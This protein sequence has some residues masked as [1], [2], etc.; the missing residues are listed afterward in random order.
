MLPFA[1]HSLLNNTSPLYSQLL[2]APPRGPSAEDGLLEAREIMNLKL[3]AELAV[4]SACETGIGEVKNGEGVYGLRRALAL[5][6]AES[7]V[8]SLWQVSDIGTRDLM[9]DF[10]KRLKA[11]EGRAEAFRHAQLDMLSDKNRSHP[12]YWASFIQSG[13]WTDLNGKR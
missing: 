6:G 1:T 4:L 8:M 2:L 7:Q 3:N 11:G 12:Y 13:A 9:V 10:Y 5:A